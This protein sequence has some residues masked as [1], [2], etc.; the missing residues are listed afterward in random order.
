MI[1]R[2]ICAAGMELVCRALIFRTGPNLLKLGLSLD[3]LILFS[4]LAAEIQPSC[5][6]LRTDRKSLLAA[7]GACAA[8]K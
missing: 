6:H 7:I 8:I 2:S 4:K 1:K 3:F 5:E